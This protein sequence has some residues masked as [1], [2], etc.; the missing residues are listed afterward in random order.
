MWGNVSS[1]F[2]EEAQERYLMEKFSILKIVGSDKKLSS[3]AWPILSV[4]FAC[5]ALVITGFIS[6]EAVVSASDPQ[7]DMLGIYVLAGVTAF[8]ALLSVSLAVFWIKRCAYFK[9]LFYSSMEY[10]V[11]VRK[12]VVK[13]FEGATQA[14][15]ANG[16]GNGKV[17]YIYH[18]GIKYTID[19]AKEADDPI[20]KERASANKKLTRITGS[21]PYD[22][23]QANKILD[24]GYFMIRYDKKSDQGLYFKPR[25]ALDNKKR[26]GD[27]HV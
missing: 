13:V 1:I 5:V 10:I 26:E 22:R 19:F 12:T 3:F 16:Y 15:R 18:Y 21:Y 23:L 11:E 2:Y 20:V 17:G 7:R 27:L 4:F 8:F 25:Y 9:K 6:H 24:S 14:D